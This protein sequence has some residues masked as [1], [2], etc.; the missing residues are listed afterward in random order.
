[1]VSILPLLSNFPSFKTSG[2]IPS[3]LTTIGITVSLVFPCF[4]SSHVAL[5]GWPE[6]TIPLFVSAWNQ[7]K[8]FWTWN[9]AVSGSCK[10]TR[11]ESW[12]EK[13][14]GRQLTTGPGR[15]QL[16]TGQQRELAW[17]HGQMR[18]TP[19]TVA[20]KRGSSHGEEDWVKRCR[21]SS[22]CG[23]FASNPR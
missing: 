10:G 5:Y 4:F 16:A 7:T 2:A 17:N 13:G 22:A 23:I 14:A 8:D 12:V 19:E 1:M 3:A 11:K 18:S 21:H 6:Q 20:E 9:L 15:G